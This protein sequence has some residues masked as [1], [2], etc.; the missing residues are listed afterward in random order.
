[1]HHFAQPVTPNAVEGLLEVYVANV[2]SA[3]S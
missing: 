2:H 3:D 1:L